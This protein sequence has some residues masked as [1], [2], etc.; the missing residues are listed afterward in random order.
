[1]DPEKVPEADSAPIASKP[2]R[3]PILDLEGCI[4][5]ASDSKTQLETLQG[6]R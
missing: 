3:L 2:R 6:Y 5:E 1:M 4:V